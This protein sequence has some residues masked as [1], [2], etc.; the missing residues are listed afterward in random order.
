[1]VQI[2][3]TIPIH[4]GGCAAY[5]LLVNVEYTEGDAEVYVLPLTFVTGDRA[6]QLLQYLAHTVLARLRIEDAA[7][8]GVL[9]DPIVEQDFCTI[10]LNA[11]KT[12]RRMRAP[13]GEVTASP[14]RI[15]SIILNATDAK[16]EA[17][18]IKAEQSNSSVIYGD[19][20]ILKIF[21][22]LEPGI[23]PDLEIGRF[24][25]EHGFQHTPP[26]AGMLEYQRSGTEPAT[27]A[28]L[29]GFVTNEA[30]PGNTRWMCRATILNAH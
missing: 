1:M 24:L 13:N 25:T 10:L 8:E 20:L 9:Y 27:L 7:I 28:I 16:L 18:P 14:T 5:I 11:I 26:V 23:N 6:E 12:R 22:K 15:L 17:N 30:M 3:D 4:S 21:R 19:R 29:Q 2:V